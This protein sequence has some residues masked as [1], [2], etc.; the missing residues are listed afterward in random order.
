MYQLIVWEVEGVGWYWMIPMGQQVTLR[1]KKP[2]VSYDLALD[3]GLYT[4]EKVGVPL[5]AA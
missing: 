5:V 3:L 1:S 2:E 4:A